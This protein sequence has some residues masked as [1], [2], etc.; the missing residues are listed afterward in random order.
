MFSSYVWS[1]PADEKNIYLSFDDG[2]HPEITPFVLEE[3]KKY[4][5]QASFFC[6]GDRV[7]QYP[8]VYKQILDEGHV[9]GNHTYSHPNGWETPLKE[10]MKDIAAASKYIESNLFRPPY[11]RIKRQQA[12]GLKKAMNNDDA[13]IIMWDVLSAD[14]DPSFSPRKCLDNVVNNC[15]N[16]SIVVF[17]DSEKAFP[18]LEY[19]LPKALEKLED[20]GYSFKRIEG[21]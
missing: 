2:P 14:F 4:S 16:G 11:G 20:D 1:M 6:V 3:L 18:N 15:T 5:A 9:V 7:V 21:L 13:K 12:K 8:E 17:H 10:Y 19:S